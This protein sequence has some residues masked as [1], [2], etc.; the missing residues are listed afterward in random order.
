MRRVLR[1]AL[2]FA[3]TFCLRGASLG[4]GFLFAARFLAATFFFAIFFLETCFWVTF[5]FN[6]GFFRET[7]FRLA[8]FLVVFFLATTFFFDALFAEDFFLLTFRFLPAGFLRLTE[9]AGAAFF[10]V[11]RAFFRFLFAIIL[12]IL[13]NRKAR[14]YTPVVATWKGIYGCF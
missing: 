2:F 8:A 3:A 11:A 14:N 6:A 10:L 12:K 13:P 7:F 5:C 9:R 1:A 4:T